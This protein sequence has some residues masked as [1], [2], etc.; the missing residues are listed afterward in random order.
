MNYVVKFY[1]ETSLPA[2]NRNQITN[3]HGKEATY[4]KLFILFSSFKCK[5]SNS[6]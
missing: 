1:V 2:K 6:V 5:K 3:I 4:F